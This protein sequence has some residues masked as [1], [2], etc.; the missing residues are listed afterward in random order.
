MP[1]KGMALMKSSRVTMKDIADAAGCSVNTVSRA[2]RGDSLISPET[3]A[4]IQRIA[5]DLKYIRNS[6]ASSLRSGRSHI[7]AVVVNDIRNYHFCHLLSRMDSDLRAAGYSLMILCMHL[8]DTLASQ[9][10]QAAVSMSVDGVFYFPNMDHKT[11][12]QLLE[13]N[14]IPY[15]LIDREV[16]G[17]EA[18][19][20]RSDDRLGGYLAGKHLLSLGHRKFLFLSGVEQSS[21]QWDRLDGFMQA[22]DEE[23]VSRSCARVIPGEDVEQAVAGGR[24]WELLEPVDYTGIVSF[25]DEVSYLVLKD[26]QQRG[27]KIP[28]D[29][30]LISFDHLCAE[31]PTL[32]P[33]TS[34]YTKDKNIAEE[35][36]KLLLQKMD[37]PDLSPVKAILPVCIYDEGTTG[38]PRRNV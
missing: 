9:L 5:E 33:V 2:L 10:V 12:V 30:S 7:V 34:I 23:N 25:R 37:S 38:V 21:S 24:I 35:A 19:V 20:V 13:N 1:M 31:N 28:E 11:P 22:L 29:V 18:D 17:V 26:L 3:R 6:A 27:W 4:E 36:V 16:A 8:D 32:P 14:R 15:V